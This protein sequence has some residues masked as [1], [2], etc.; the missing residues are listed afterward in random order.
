MINSLQDANDPLVSKFTDGELNPFK[1]QNWYHSPENSE[2]DESGVK[3][4]IVK[5]IQWRSDTVINLI[6]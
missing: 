3:K 4:I 2:T 1:K 5:D 6:N